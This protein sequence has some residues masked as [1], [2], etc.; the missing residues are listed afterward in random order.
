MNNIGVTLVIAIRFTRITNTSTNYQLESR[1][2]K[3]A[4]R[5]SHPICQ[6]KHLAR[7][8]IIERT[9]LNGSLLPVE[10]QL[11]FSFCL[12]NISRSLVV[13]Q[14]STV[15]LSSSQVV[16]VWQIAVLRDCVVLIV[17]RLEDCEARRRRN[18]RELVDARPANAARCC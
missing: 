11:Q 10:S 7:V 3:D 13:W 2:E 18:K 4:E 17:C 15:G 16:C 5:F 8:L 14:I 12:S 9:L 6:C 1:V